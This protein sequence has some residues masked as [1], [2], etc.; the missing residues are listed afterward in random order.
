[1]C[2]L[3][4]FVNQDK[5]ETKAPGGLLEPLPIPKKPWDSVNM[6]CI[7][8]LPNSKGL[9]TIMVVMDRF[10]KY[11]TFIATTVSCKAKEAA[12]IFLRDVVKYWGIPKHIISD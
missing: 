7:T 3:V 12:H 5:V 8:C 1:M 10:S 9:G 2:G 6:D 11:A 4:L